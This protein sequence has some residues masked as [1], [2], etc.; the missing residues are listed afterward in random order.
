MQIVGVKEDP[1]A[2]VKWLATAWGQ[3]THNAAEMER[4]ENSNG[5][6]GLARDAGNKEQPLSYMRLGRS[7]LL[8]A[9]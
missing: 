2:Q 6:R 9:R 1:P 4:P 3:I 8:E 5:H 7:V